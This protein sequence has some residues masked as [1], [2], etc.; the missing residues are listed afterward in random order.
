MQLIWIHLYFLFLAQCPPQLVAEQVPLQ[1]CLSGSVLTNPIK[2][3][4]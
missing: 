4:H 2:K 1:D 3:Q